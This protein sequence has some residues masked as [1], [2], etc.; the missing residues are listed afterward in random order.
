MIDD[1]AQA[2]RVAGQLEA[3]APGGRQVERAGGGNQVLPQG[4]S[5]EM[6]PA[7]LPHESF[8]K[9]SFKAYRLYDLCGI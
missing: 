7:S 5:V 6:S 1:R 3:S 2:K 8:V 9:S 4:R